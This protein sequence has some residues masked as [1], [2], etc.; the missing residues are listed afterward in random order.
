M[1]RKHKGIPAEV[2]M[3]LEAW[4]SGPDSLRTQFQRRNVPY[5]KAQYWAKKQGLS[6][7][8]PPQQLGPQPSTATPDFI[9]VDVH[10][11]SQARHDLQLTLPSGTVLMASDTSL[12]ALFSLL[13][14]YGL[15]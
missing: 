12:P 6:R 10:Q 3:V 8:Q 13:R 2:T 9:R 14:Q 4:L 1:P 5:W 11:P 7:Q 15:C